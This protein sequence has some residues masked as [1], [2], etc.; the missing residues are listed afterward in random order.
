MRS[1]LRGFR[2]SVRRKWKPLAKQSGRGAAV[3]QSC[4]GRSADRTNGTLGRLRDRGGPATRITSGPCPRSCG[5]FRETE[6]AFVTAVFEDQPLRSDRAIVAHP[7]TRR[8]ST[9]DG[10]GL[11]GG[12]SLRRTDVASPHDRRRR[13][14]HHSARRDPTHRPLPEL[15]DPV[16]PHSIF[17]RRGCSLVVPCQLPRGSIGSYRA[18]AALAGRISRSLAPIRRVRSPCHRPVDPPNRST[19]RSGIYPATAVALLRA[20]SRGIWQHVS[21]RG[22]HLDASSC[23]NGLRRPASVG[24]SSQ[25][26][27]PS[28]S[29]PLDGRLTRTTID[30]PIYR[31]RYNTTNGPW[32][33]L[34]DPERRRARRLR[35][36]LCGN[37]NQ[38]TIRK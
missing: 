31:R 1:P 29:S 2:L 12:L 18:G 36:E 20:A 32:T 6:H 16:T 14:L 25:A 23:D 21:R 27:R 19:P 24:R 28:S 4:V 22:E 38:S 15:I 30:Y 3:A 37:S 7:T 11:T 17:V 35:W 10:R 8:S 33:R 5:V 9:S 34:L 26:S 13:D